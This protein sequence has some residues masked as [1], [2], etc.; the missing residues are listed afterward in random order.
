[1]KRIFGF[2]IIAAVLGLG[3]SRESGTTVRVAQFTTDPNL[4]K[5]ISEAAQGIEKRHPGLRVQLVN[6][7]YNNYIEKIT[8]QFAANNVPDVVYVEVNNFVDLYLRGAFM[9]LTPYCQKDALDLTG[10]YPGV[11]GR[12]SPG[13][14]VYAIP[15]DTAPSGLVYYNKKF[16]Q[17]AGLP[18]PTNKWKWPEPFLSICQKLVKKNATGKVVRWAYSDP[19][20]IQF[21]SFMLSNG[22]NWVDDTDHPTRLTMDS[23]QALEA[24]RFRWEMIHKYHVSPDPSEIQTFNFSAG[25]E[26]M[27][28]NGKIAMMASGIWHTPKFL[29]AKDL[30]FDVVEFPAGPKGLKGWSSG[31]SG[32]AMSKDSKN[33]DLAW[34]VIKEMTS[35]ATLTQLAATGMIQPALKKLADSD[36]FLKAPGAAH[37]KILLAM[38]QYSHYQPFVGNWNE[39]LYGALT[40]ALDPVWIGSKTPEEVLPEVTKRINEKFFKKDK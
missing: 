8:T 1:M 11:L 18:F 38:P 31:G 23:P 7:P 19:Y 3:C 36:V 10:Y 30:D 33:K 28:M 21:D 27:F 12:F 22:G 26:D 20:A 29:K 2:F 24:A 9:D 32:Y 16:F 14:R 25:A 35:E 37:K 34:M 6:I 15:Q 39:I 13:G 5:I 40:P 4:I 17:E